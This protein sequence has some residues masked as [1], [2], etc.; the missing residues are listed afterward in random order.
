MKSIANFKVLLLF[1]RHKAWFWT[2]AF[3]TAYFLFILSQDTAKQN[4]Y[5]FA[6]ETTEFLSLSYIVIPTYLIILTTHFSVGNIQNY[7]AFRCSNRYAWY[8]INLKAVAIV[9]TVF[10]FVILAIPLLLATFVFDFA[11]HWS[12]FALNFYSYHSIFLQ[13][14][15][16]VFYLIG[17]FSL[18]WLLLFCLGLVFYLVYLTFR[19]PFIAVIV[20]LLLNIINISATASRMDW[21]SRF[22]WTKRVSIFEYIYMTEANQHMFPF[23]I[24]LYWLLLIGFFY[25][26]GYLIVHK[27]DL[28]TYRGENNDVY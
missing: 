27:T 20:I 9:T 12:D 26:L 13:H 19:R 15:S 28:D 8:K 25:G 18:L 2:T 22:F 14:V 6:I 3:L 5:D 21:L 7:F 11:N 24:F 10:T 4:F 1:S 16:P 17:T 23:Q